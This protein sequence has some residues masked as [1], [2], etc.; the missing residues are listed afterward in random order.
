M[1][2]KRIVDV[3]I[4]VD[5]GFKDDILQVAQSLQAKGLLLTEMIPSVGVLR[6]TI[7]FDLLENISS[8]EGVASIETDETPIG[9]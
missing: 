8:T 1:P 4:L 3:T 5:G 7:C 2:L 6:G 9:S